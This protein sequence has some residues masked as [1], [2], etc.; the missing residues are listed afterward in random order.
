VSLS[1]YPVNLSRPHCL[2]LQYLAR[3]P[4]VFRADIG[5]YLQR[6]LGFHQGQGGYSN[7]TILYHFGLL[8]PVLRRDGAGKI[9]ISKTTGRPVAIRGKSEI[10]SYG[11][12]F[13][14]GEDPAP[15]TLTIYDRQ[16]LPV[17]P[18]TPWLY[19]DQVVHGHSHPHAAQ[20]LWDRDRHDP[21][22]GQAM[23]A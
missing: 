8:R 20:P 23:S 2:G 9:V 18:A 7:F 13:V 11:I 10:T 12:A 6:E 22:P 15:L 1:P 14:N 17:D 4:E 5:L 16:P 3:H 19:F 21:G